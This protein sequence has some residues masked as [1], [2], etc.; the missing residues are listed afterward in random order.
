M[1]IDIKTA[2]RAVDI[3]ITQARRW[4]LDN[5]RAMAA[6]LSETG[7]I[8]TARYED[9]LDS[10]AYASAWEQVQRAITL[11]GQD[12]PGADDIYE[13]AIR[14]RKAAFISDLVTGGQ[15]ALCVSVLHNEKERRARDIRCRV[16]R[17]LEGVEELFAG[18]RAARSA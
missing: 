13:R 1:A 4:R 8:D 17:E 14:A 7:E 5:E 12:F 16:I 3:Y 2:E 18:I 10:R 6:E 15:G 11:L 9:H